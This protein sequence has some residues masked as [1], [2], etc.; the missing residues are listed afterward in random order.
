MDDDDDDIV[1]VDVDVMLMLMSFPPEQRCSPNDVSFAVSVVLR[2]SEVH[3]ATTSAEIKK[4]RGTTRYIDARVA[5][6]LRKKG[7]TLQLVLSYSQIPPVLSDGPCTP[8]Q[9]A[10][11]Q[12]AARS[13]TAD[14]WA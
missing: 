3:R 10:S 9:S 1:D 6:P 12:A 5:I 11:L 14:L 13:F 2:N 7:T 4:Q 8:R